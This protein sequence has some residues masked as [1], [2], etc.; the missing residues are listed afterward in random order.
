MRG[1]VCTVEW[2]DWEF[3]SLSIC[4]WEDY[5]FARWWEKGKI[6]RERDQLRNPFTADFSSH[7]YEIIQ[8]WISFTERE[9]GGQTDNFFQNC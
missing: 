1:C 5:R 4:M 3:I 2:E 7:K 6:C 9:I 8:Q